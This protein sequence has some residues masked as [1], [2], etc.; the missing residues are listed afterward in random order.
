[1]RLTTCLT[2]LLI[3]GIGLPYATADDLNRL[4]HDAA[5]GSR[6]IRL[7]ALQ[8]LGNSGD[9]RA[10]QPLLTALDD[11]DPTIRSCAIAALQA[12]ARSLDG[13][14]R[15]IVQWINSLVDALQIHTS[16]PPPEVEHTRHLQYI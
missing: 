11:R 15:T 1:M 12:L 2:A 6:E 3:L 4:L 7:Q 9:V 16:P 5:S 10:L 8:T 13:V 14:Y